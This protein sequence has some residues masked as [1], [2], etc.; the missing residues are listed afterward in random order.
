VS[1]ALVAFLIE[2]ETAPTLRERFL[3]VAALDRDEILAGGSEFEAWLGG[4]DPAR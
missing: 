4:F 2:R 3:R 1:L